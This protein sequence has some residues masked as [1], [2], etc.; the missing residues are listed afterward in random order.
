MRPTGVAG[1]AKKAEKRTA[2]LDELK[3]RLVAACWGKMRDV[4]CLEFGVAVGRSL[5]EMLQPSYVKIPG[6]CMI[7]FEQQL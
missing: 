6:A 5:N 4:P 7:G 3:A 1:T 2:V